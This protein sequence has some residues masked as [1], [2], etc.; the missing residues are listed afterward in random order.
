VSR[1]RRRDSGK[2]WTFF[3]KNN[4][5]IKGDKRP[6]PSARGH[7]PRSYSNPVDL[8]VD[9]SRLGFTALSS[10]SDDSIEF[11]ASYSPHAVVDAETPVLVRIALVRSL[12]NQHSVVNALHF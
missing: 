3:I 2:V 4:E 11:A 12:I 8:T 5:V 7:L 1:Q 10:D 9:P 6:A